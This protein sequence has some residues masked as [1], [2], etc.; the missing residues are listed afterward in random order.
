MDTK[1]KEYKKTWRERNPESAKRSAK[2]YNAKN[3]GRIAEHNRKI[4]RENKE[5]MDILGLGWRRRNPEK[6][7]FSRIRSRAKRSGVLF[8]LSVEDI[9]IP[10]ECP[11]CSD[12]MIQG[13]GDGG[14]SWN[15]P[16]LDKI[17][18]GLGYTASNVWV[19]CRRCNSRK[20]DSSPEQMRK[21]AT[22]TA[23]EIK[24]RRL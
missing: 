18:P 8:D 7:M 17:I 14:N 4:Y 15:S 10:T 19:I 22:A 20:Q 11:I 16:S 1:S 5:H 13:I 9:V 2:K 3:R 21:I 6:V 23:R 24:K 12:V